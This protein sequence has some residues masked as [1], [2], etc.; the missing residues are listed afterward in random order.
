MGPTASLTGFPNA[1]VKLWLVGTLLGTIGYGALI[2]LCL[3]CAINYIHSNA[4]GRRGSLDVGY[5]K[6]TS[7]GR[8]F[9]PYILWMF[10]LSTLAVVCS[11]IAL[12][13]VLFPPPG[14]AGEVMTRFVRFGGVVS[15]V[16]ASWTA[17]A[18]VIWRCVILYEDASRAV[19]FSVDILLCIT[20]LI[21]LGLGLTYLATSLTDLNKF[22]L[23]FVLATSICNSIMTTLIVL[24]LSY[25]QR[26]IQKALGSEYGSPYARVMVMCVESAALIVVFNLAHVCAH[27]N[28]NIGLVLSHQ[29]LVHVYGISALLIL[30]RVLSGRIRGGEIT[31]DEIKLN[32]QDARFSLHFSTCSSSTQ[33]PRNDDDYPR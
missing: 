19:R 6:G 13:D 25:H 29:L 33:Y 27:F 14:G 31:S 21:S 30:Y 32:T 1:N 16:V 26:F 8:F 24:R 28:S 17:D 9:L 18:L 7:F 11:C 2:V 5:R 10:L 15:L 12:V 3:G 4:A 22:M 23:I 20:A